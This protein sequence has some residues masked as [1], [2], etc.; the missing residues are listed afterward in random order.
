[1][2]SI[3]FKNKIITR[4][5]LI[6]VLYHLHIDASVNINEQ[7]MNAIE[8]NRLRDRISQKYL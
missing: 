2:C 6:D 8:S 4:A 1:M 5:F 3:Y 7:I